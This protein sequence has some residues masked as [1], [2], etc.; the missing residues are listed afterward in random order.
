MGLR[1]SNGTIAR[2][3][4][5][6]TRRARERAPG[7][8]LQLGSCPAG[9]SGDLSITRTSRTLIEFEPFLHSARAPSSLERVTAH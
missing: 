3:S 1:G 8:R 5:R 7:G 6:I 9:R 2:V 4:A